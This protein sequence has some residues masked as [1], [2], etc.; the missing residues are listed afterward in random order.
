MEQPKP[1]GKKFA[2]IAAGD[3]AGF[4]TV[5]SAALVDEF[6]RVSGDYSPLH[7]DGAYAA[8]T[9]YEK[10]VAH[11]MLAGALFS[12][13]L[14]MQLPGLYCVYLSQTLQ[15]KKP[16]FLKTEVTIKGVVTAK[17]DATQTLT[18]ALQMQDVKTGEVFAAGEAVVKVLK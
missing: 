16:V 11:G 4:S 2:D 1:A 5:I 15:F 8:T 14:G 10:R 18:I 9:P 17:S 6:A 7:V 13:L 3:T 12:R